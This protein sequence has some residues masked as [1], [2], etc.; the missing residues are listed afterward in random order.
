MTRSA[1][2]RGLQFLQL[3][4]TAV[5]SGLSYWE[6]VVIQLRTDEL[7]V[8]LEASLSLNKEQRGP[9]SDVCSVSLFP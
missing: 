7:L 5:N 2:T 1:K 4:D 6:G 9:L 3:S 8:I